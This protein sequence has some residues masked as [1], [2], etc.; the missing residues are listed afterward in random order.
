MTWDKCP[1]WNRLSVG[2]APSHCRH[3]AAMDAMVGSRRST[4]PIHGV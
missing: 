3:Q 4:E 2:S 1:S